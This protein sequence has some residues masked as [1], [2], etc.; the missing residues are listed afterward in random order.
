[1]NLSLRDQDFWSR[2]KKYLFATVVFGHEP[3]FFTSW[4]RL[5]VMNRNICSRPWCLATNHNF[6]FV[7][8]T[9]GHKQRNN[10]SRPWSSATNHIFSLRDQD[11][12]SR[13][14]KYLLMTMI[15]GHEPQFFYFVTETSGHEQGN[16][17]FFGHEQQLLSL[18]PSPLVT[19]QDIFVYNLYLL[20]QT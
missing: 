1:M 19:K 11:L 12:W 20:S 17:Y 8:K 9:S 6:Y 15:F 14:Q 10:C 2:T 13:T 7:T 18:W 4:P 5:L 16:I 3:H